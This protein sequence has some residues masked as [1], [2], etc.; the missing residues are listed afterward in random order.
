MSNTDLDHP[1]TQYVRREP[2][3]TCLSRVEISWQPASGQ[4]RSGS[5]L[6]E[7]ISPSG[8]GLRVRTALPVGSL[9]QIK[10]RNQLRTATVR[11]CVRADYEYSIGIQ[12]CPDLVENT[13]SD[14]TPPEN[15]APAT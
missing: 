7:D 10:A 5:A 11:S 8:M 3:K 9:V 2:R 14:S 4:L 12:F 1:R 6:M 13:G 15:L